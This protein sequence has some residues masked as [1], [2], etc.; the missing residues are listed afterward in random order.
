[1]NFFTYTLI[2][3]QILMTVGGQVLWKKSFNETGG[4]LLPGQSFIASFVHMLVNPLFIIGTILYAGAT[5][6]WFYLLSRFEL[7]L[8]YPFLSLTYVVSFI[9]AWWFLGETISIQKLGAV[10]LITV[11]ILLLAK[12]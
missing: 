8:L 1:M 4:F 7:S 2:G 11:G 3:I 12:T 6:L 10:G 5:L 9:M